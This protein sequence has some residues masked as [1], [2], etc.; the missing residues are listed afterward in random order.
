MAAI[1]CC[2][3]WGSRGN[4]VVMSLHAFMSACGQSASSPLPPVPA[5]RP[6][7]GLSTDIKPLCV[8]NVRTLSERR[9][10]K[11]REGNVPVVPPLQAKAQ[12]ALGSPHNG[13]AQPPDWT[14]QPPDWTSR[15]P[16]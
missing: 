2:T 11:V 16:D 1:A 9:V 6:S 15:P 10:R 3:H 14:A 12:A 7:L 4:S 5:T 8:T 13:T